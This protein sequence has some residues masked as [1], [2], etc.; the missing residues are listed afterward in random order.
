MKK[1]PFFLTLSAF[2]VLSAACGKRDAAPASEGEATRAV[3]LDTARLLADQISRSARLYTTEYQIHKIVTHSDEARLRG[4]VLSLPVNVEVST[5]DRKIAIPIDV[6]VKA[7]IDFSSFSSEDIRISDGRLS[8]TLP[9]PRLTVTASRIDNAGVRQYVDL[10][11]STFTD[12]EVLNLARQ[13]ADSVVSHLDRPDLLQTAR[14]GARRALLPL[15]RRVGFPPDR[16]TLAFRSGLK[17][18]DLTFT[19]ENTPYVEK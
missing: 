2:L 18:E 10:T 6:T 7:Y 17:P 12:S 1:T 3:R 19:L 13:G 11:R 4:N 16:V 8:L 15:L 14:E 5:G 9:D